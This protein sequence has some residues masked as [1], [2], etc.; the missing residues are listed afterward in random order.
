MKKITF[1]LLLIAASLWTACDDECAPVNCEFVFPSPGENICQAIM[2]S[3]LYNPSTGTC[4]QISY[5]GCSQQGFSTQEECK[6]NCPC[7]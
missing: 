3:W 2:T 7:D 1:I 6:I 5:T 4:E